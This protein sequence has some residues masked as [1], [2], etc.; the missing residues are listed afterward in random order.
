MLN[1]GVTQCLRCRVRVQ[2]E[3]FRG[4]LGWGLTAPNSIIVP[5]NAVGLA[6]S[7]IYYVNTASCFA[8]VTQS[9]PVFTTNPGA[10]E[11]R[12]S[13]S[14]LNSC[15]QSWEF[16][17]QAIASECG[18]CLGLTRRYSNTAECFG[19]QICQLPTTQPQRP[20]STT[21][22]PMLPKHSRHFLTSWLGIFAPETTLQWPILFPT[23]AKGRCGSGRSGKNTTIRMPNEKNAKGSLRPCTGNQVNKPFLFGAY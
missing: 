4:G 9:T 19:S 1:A 14:C 10:A 3:L 7:V 18:Q 13:Y 5:P 11:R 15:A 20:R 23:R 16:S 8:S 21:A 17:L 12:F 6:A 2:R 22:F